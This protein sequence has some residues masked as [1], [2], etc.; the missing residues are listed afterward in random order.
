MHLHYLF[1]NFTYFFHLL[2]ID[3][4]VVYFPDLIQQ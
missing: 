3:D 4:I 2:S 1:E